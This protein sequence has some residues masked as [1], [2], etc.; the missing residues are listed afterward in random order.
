M[1]LFNVQSLFNLLWIW[2]SKAERD[3]TM[4]QGFLVLQSVDWG[5]Q[6][7]KLIWFSPYHSLE[8]FSS[9]RLR[10]GSD[11]DP[12]LC[13]HLLWKVPRPPWTCNFI[14]N[15]SLVLLG[16]C[17]YLCPFLRKDEPN[18]KCKIQHEWDA[19]LSKFLWIFC[20]QG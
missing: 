14:S 15:R 13:R 10:K 3:D 8:L 5:G 9:L 11:G 17:R 4:G 19:K 18:S 7:A 16:H 6:L 2:P 20:V 12:G 1:P